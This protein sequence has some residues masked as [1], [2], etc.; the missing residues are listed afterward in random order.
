MIK[1]W[2]IWWS[3]TSTGRWGP[4]IVALVYWAVAAAIG[5]LTSGHIILVSFL[6]VFHYAGPRL[7]LLRDLA[8]PL[9]IILIVYDSQRLW[10]E[11]VRGPI[12]V[13]DLHA[14][15]LAWF[16]VGEGD[17]RV[18]LAR[19]WQ[20]RTHPVLDAITGV[21]YLSYV[22]AFLCCVWCFWRQGNNIRAVMWTFLALNISGY[23][24]YVIYPAAPPWYFDLYG[25]GPARLDVPGSAAGAVR[26]D[27][28]VGHPIF[29]DIYEKNANVFG[30]M[31]SIHVAVPFLALLFALRFRRARIFSGVVFVAIA[32]AAVYLNHHYVWDIV[33]GLVIALSVFLINLA[34]VPG[35]EV[36]Q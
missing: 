28:L 31:P 13:A 22:P 5:L 20:T 1:E 32:F 35:K 10:V 18:T 29:A 25:M 6:L 7:R 3:A 24:L 2:R 33:V 30:A 15:E 12:H 21:A 19:W 34:V 26:F 36:S 27:E 17:D 23:A 11:D 16:G 4:L 14:A 9:V 8:L